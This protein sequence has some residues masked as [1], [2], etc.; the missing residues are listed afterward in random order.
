MAIEQA[1]RSMRACFVRVNNS[2]LKYRKLQ[3]FEVHSLSPRHTRSTLAV[4]SR[5]RV[6]SSSS[7]L[8]TI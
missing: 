5:Q 7:S 4:K 3:P 6:S 2:F 8:R 1:T